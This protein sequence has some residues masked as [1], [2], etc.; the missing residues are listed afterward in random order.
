MH[1][2]P[3][4]SSNEISPTKLTRTIGIFSSQVFATLGCTNYD[5]VD[6][7]KRLLESLNVE[8][9]LLQHDYMHV[10]LELS[11]LGNQNLSLGKFL[12]IYICIFHVLNHLLLICKL[13]WNQ[14][15]MNTPFMSEQTIG[16]LNKAAIDI[17]LLEEAR[18]MKV[19]LDSDGCQCTTRLESICTAGHHMLLLRHAVLADDWLAVKDLLIQNVVEIND[20]L[21]DL[22]THYSDEI[23]LLEAELEARTVVEAIHESLEI[24]PLD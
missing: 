20:E 23:F 12:P 24:G 10:N 3:P 7:Q 18:D 2:L 19:L 9:V 14:A 5:D 17:K 1:I 13:H 22:M 16:R 6:E 15:A 21:N 4:H 11:Y 8:F